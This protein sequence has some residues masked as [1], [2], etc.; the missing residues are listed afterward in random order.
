MLE[1]LTLL[2]RRASSR[3]PGHPDSDGLLGRAV[4][5]ASRYELTGSASAAL[6]RHTH[7]QIYTFIYDYLFICPICM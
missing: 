3:L 2:V 1:G 6:A 7:T 5:L 4:A